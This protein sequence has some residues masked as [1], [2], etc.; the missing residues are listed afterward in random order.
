[1]GIRIGIIGV[2][3]LGYLQTQ[4]YRDIEGVS[5]V[6]AADVTAEARDLFEREFHA[7][8]Y[9]SYR[10][11]LHEHEDDLDAVT[12]VTPHTLHHEQTMACLDR[13]L[14]VLVEKPMVTDVGHAVDIVETAAD[15]D[16][17]VQV[18]YQRR[19]HPA[20]KEMRRIIRERRLGNLHTVS[21]FVSQNWI[22]N[23]RNSW[24]VNPD[25]AGG[26][27]LYDTGS[28]LLDAL[29]WLTNAEPRS[30]SA[31]IEY[32]MPGVDVNSTLSL[33]LAH[34]ER[35]IIAS[36]AIC[37]D[38]VDVT[39]SE[40]YFFWGSEGYMAYA[41]DELVVTE[42]TGITYRTEITS[43]Y[44]FSVLNEYKLE[45]FI[46]AIEGQSQPAVP[47]SDGLE[48]TALT[49][50]TYEADEVQSRVGVQGIIDSSLEE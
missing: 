36:V 15:R 42:H 31:D 19:F 8:A 4:T 34:D 30:V 37:G 39:P 44:D 38:G 32:A 16:L 9:D 27:Q 49:E 12:I 1:M 11:L 20:F 26:G 7:P 29:L 28:H 6:A 23:H 18:G 24:R 22:E 17:V 13:G 43:D 35:D 40:G 14:H 3:G 45:N 48:V 41:S 5:I 10:S 2:G 46:D 50:A 47:A 21:C 33:R 25:L